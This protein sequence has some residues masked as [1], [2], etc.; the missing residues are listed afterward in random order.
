M[1]PLV[2][3]DENI[4][5]VH[6]LLGDIATIR[7]VA[8]REIDAGALAGAEAL[9]VRSVTRVNAALVSV[10]RLRFVGSATSGTD[11][12]DL[13]CLRDSGIPF[14]HAPGSNANSVVEYVLAAIA[15][16]PGKLDGILQ[17]GIYG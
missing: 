17:A 3:V 2:V 12:I 10:S 5:G 14:A 11:H 6:E 9:L 4:P 7:T 15:A 13:E 8:G 16:V 1:K